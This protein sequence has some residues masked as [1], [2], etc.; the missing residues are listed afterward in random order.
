MFER[1]YIKK[2]RITESQ[3]DLGKLCEA[4]LF[5]DQTDFMLDRFTAT[6][7]VELMP[8]EKLKEYTSKGIINLHSRNTAI[9][10]IQLEKGNKTGVAP[11]V[12]KSDAHNLDEY[13]N[14]GFL[15]KGIS[16]KEAS[17][18]TDDF[19]GLCAKQ[20]YVDGF[21]KMLEAECEDEALLTSQLKIYINSY[22]PQLSLEDLTISI[23][24]KFL[25][26]VGIEA[27]IYN[28][29]Y[30]FKT[31]NDKYSDLFPEGHTLNWTSFLLNSSE[32]SGDLNIAS[33]HNAEIFTD[34]NHYPYLQNRLSE[35]IIKSKTNE[36]NITIF[37]NIELEG[38]RPIRESINS[39]E[40]SFEDF[41]E[42]L[43]KSLKF[44]K[45]LRNL[46]DDHTLLNQYYQTVIKE[47]WIEKKIAKAS[48]FG[49]FTALG[50]L[51][52]AAAGGIPIG[53]A[54]ASVSDNYLL[55][56]LLNGWKP[57]Q[58]IDNEVKPFL[59]TE[60]NN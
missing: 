1:I 38:Y 6:Q 19:L 25:T 18:M 34:R 8:F 54:A 28:S 9:G 27:Y 50:M 17:T 57:N 43:D 55:P 16:K 11:M 2:N 47:S 22:L 26:P 21:Q 59:K 3:I 5:Y 29:N 32:S 60:E 15:N 7:F 53:S 42:V 41:V 46:S 44:R 36:D 35:L 52:D 56:K 33:Q 10:I 24:D 48:R 14:Q 39:G 4:L 31:L 30:D 51:G 20:E 58:F 49:I 13:V 45:W 40:K 12:T 37:E 23:S